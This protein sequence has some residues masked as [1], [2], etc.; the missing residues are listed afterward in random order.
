MVRDIVGPGFTLIAGFL[1]ASFDMA[2]IGGVVGD[3]MSL[4]CEVDRGGTTYMNSGACPCTQPV[5]PSRELIEGCG[6]FCLASQFAI[7]KLRTTNRQRRTAFGTL[8]RRSG[9]PN[10][11][12]TAKVPCASTST[13][14]HARLAFSGTP[15]RHSKTAKVGE[16]R[17]RAP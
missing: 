10:H 17:N 16:L 14:S 12:P 4:F 5:S 8:R 1:K 15:C 11:L 6:C 9:R 7:V 3:A 13:R 2:E